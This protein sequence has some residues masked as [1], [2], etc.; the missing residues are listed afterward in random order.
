MPAFVAAYFVFDHFNSILVL[1][2]FTFFVAL[3]PPHAFFPGWGPSY[4]LPPSPFIPHDGMSSDQE[5]Q[6]MSFL[7]WESYGQEPYVHLFLKGM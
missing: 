4:Q 7:M 2:C 6:N 5:V 3:P 1:T